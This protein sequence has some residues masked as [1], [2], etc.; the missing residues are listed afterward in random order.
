MLACWQA[1]LALN[2]QCSWDLWLMGII[3]R[4][5]T[6][7]L[8]YLRQEYTGPS[9]DGHLRHGFFCPPRDLKSL[10]KLFKVE[11]WAYVVSSCLFC[12]LL[13]AWLSRQRGWIVSFLSILYLLFLLYA[14]AYHP[15]WICCRGLIKNVLFLIIRLQTNN[16]MLNRAQ[17][18]S[19][20]NCRIVQSDLP[21]PLVVVVKYPLTCSR[22]LMR[23][24]RLQHVCTEM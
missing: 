1:L 16:H 12:L 22:L 2:I 6:E 11:Q 17:V 19:E 21:E 13:S 4:D 15:N 23:Y 10:R 14:A 5:I 3:W 8:K 24:H 7:S 9:Q 20:L 18:L